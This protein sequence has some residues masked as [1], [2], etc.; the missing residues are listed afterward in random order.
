MKYSLFSLSWSV[1]KSLLP[2]SVL[3]VPRISYLGEV[4]REEGTHSFSLLHLVL[5]LTAYS[6]PAYFS[7][8]FYKHCSCLF[9]F[10]DV[11]N[12]AQRG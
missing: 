11:A 2:F 5:F 4:E 1:L 9:S 8:H 6:K 7:R 12:W 3:T 10:V